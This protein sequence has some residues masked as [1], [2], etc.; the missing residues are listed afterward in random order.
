MTGFPRRDAL[1]FLT[2]GGEMGALIRA[3]DW[4]ST[5]LGQPET[6]PQALRTTVRLLLTSHH[7]MLIWWGPEFV[8]LY[9]DAFRQ[10]L[11]PER[12][13]SA[14]GGHGRQCWDEA[15]DIIGPQIEFVMDGRGA[16]WQ[17]DHLVP[18]T[19][20][21][22]RENV[23]WNYGYSPIDDDTKPG[24]VGGVLVICR[25][26]TEEH[27]AREALRAGE[28]RW[29][30]IFENMQEGFAL[31]EIVYGP[32]SRASDFRYIEVNAAWERLT[33][34]PPEAIVGRLA[35]EAIPGIER[36]WTDTYA[37]V[38]ETGEPAHFE[39][40]VEALGRWFEVLAYR[41]EPGRF[42]ALFLNV[43]ERRAAE[44][45]QALLSLEVD[46]R[47]K[48]ALA[49]VQA[50]LR[51]TR[52][53]DLPTF[54]RVLEGRVGTLARAQTLLAEQA[55]A[56]ADL[57]AM[58]HGEVAAFLV[59]DS[60]R[61]QVEL[62]G[63][64]VALPAAATQPLAMAV[65]ELATNAL[66]YGALSVPSGRVTVTWEFDQQ[67][68]LRLRW[69][70]HDG[71]PLTGPPQRQGFGSRVLKGTVE[72]QLGG[73]VGLNWRTSGLD[74]TIE[75]LLTHLAQAPKRPATPQPA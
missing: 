7:P 63:P 26:V 46:H 29:R 65:H 33:G 31:C 57:E 70:E 64:P 38:V 42:A 74:C 9:N 60:E 55:W 34:L 16:T 45:R 27:L 22:Q 13:P 8:Q 39:Y 51:L 5:L 44:E 49:V 17:V 19:R 61:S 50:A 28:A 47:A 69:T 43:T 48:N 66:K 73:R 56:G 15:W 67:G 62:H 58:L 36:F 35:S 14:L 52:A 32:D 3:Y 11:G 25:D 72:G 23:W 53:P 37:R 10:T 6:W 30:A 20:H 12:H 4:G 21:G 2:G 1:S 68:R 40:R 75:V 41:T 54:I 18:L 24:G 71:P 59:T